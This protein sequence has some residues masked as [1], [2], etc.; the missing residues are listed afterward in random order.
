MWNGKCVR[1]I[2]SLHSLSKLSW[3]PR[4]VADVSARR[5]CLRGCDR[6]QPSSSRQLGVW[7]PTRPH[8]VPRGR[9]SSGNNC[10]STRTTTPPPPLRHICDRSALTNWSAHRAPACS[11]LEMR[12]ST[13]ILRVSDLFFFDYVRFI[14]WLVIR[15]Q[16][17]SVRLQVHLMV[18]TCNVW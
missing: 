11:T 15:Y 18:A 5:V 16:H 8:Q 10:I 1:Y 14:R 6:V 3:S 2:V 7:P 4:C 13:D 12:N 17:P 9:K